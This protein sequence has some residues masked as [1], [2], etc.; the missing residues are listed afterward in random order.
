MSTTTR[1]RPL[2]VA[3]IGAG[4]SGIAASVALSRRGIDHVVLEEA[5]GIGGTWWKNRYPGAE[6]DLESHIY[7][8]SFARHDWRRTHA[9]WSELQQYLE[10]VARRYG[11]T[12]RLVLGERVET[13][14]WQP[15]DAVWTLRTA[16]GRDHGA[17]DAVVSGVGFLNV[18]VVPAFARGTTP[19]RGAVC[20]TSPTASRMKAWALRTKASARPT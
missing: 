6:V 17:F 5:D 9:L 11:V 18:P 2:R 1:R 20:H 15:E 16:S 8:F 19:F 10:Q 12:D 7:S 13:L 3:V 4:F 14:T